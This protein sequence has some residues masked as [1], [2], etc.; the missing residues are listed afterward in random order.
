MDQRP[1]E[2]V[3]GTRAAENLAN[4]LAGLNDGTFVHIR[5]AARATGTSRS[6]IYR[7]LNGGL[8]KREA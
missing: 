6:T 7:H 8:S 3:A 4:A 2:R 1:A 5:Q